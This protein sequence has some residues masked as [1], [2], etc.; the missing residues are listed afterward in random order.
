[1][2]VLCNFLEIKN[3]IFSRNSGAWQY[4]SAALH[5]TITQGFA[6]RVAI[7]DFYHII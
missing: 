7:S 2:C 1:M 3:E 6:G 5:R 4:D